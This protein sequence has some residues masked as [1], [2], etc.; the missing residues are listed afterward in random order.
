MFKLIVNLD[1]DSAGHGGLE[2]K[3]EVVVG[4]RVD[5]ADLLLETIHV[6]DGD[7]KAA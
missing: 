3:G 5:L 6:E 4:A 2:D 1:P 7:A